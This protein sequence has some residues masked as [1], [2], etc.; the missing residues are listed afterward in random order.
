M[1]G[2][3][4]GTG[5]SV[6]SVFER[7]EQVIVFGLWGGVWGSGSW[8]WVFSV[9]MQDICRRVQ[10]VGFGEGMLLYR[11]FCHALGGAG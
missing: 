4:F 3:E 5:L 9:G 2:D 11:V 1:Q 7:V 6:H 10:G 8:M